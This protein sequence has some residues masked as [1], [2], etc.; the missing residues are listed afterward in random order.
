[1]LVKHGHWT[2]RGKLLLIIDAVARIGG[3]TLGSYLTISDNWVNVYLGLFAGFVIYIATSHIL[4]EAHSR[5]P[6][7]VTMLTTLAGVGIMWIIVAIL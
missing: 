2:S 7:K 6:S 3:A 5:H 4:P 1:M